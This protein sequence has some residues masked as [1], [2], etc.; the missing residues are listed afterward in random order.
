MSA[1]ATLDLAKVRLEKT[2]L[3]AP[4][5]GIVGLRL[6]SIGDYVTAGQDLF[7]L[8][9]IDPIKVDFRVAERYLSAVAPGPGDRDRRRCLSGTRL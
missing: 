7:N 4:F 2:W 5:A 1:T 8:E 9:D 3:P 6:V